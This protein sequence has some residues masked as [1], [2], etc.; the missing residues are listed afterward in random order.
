MDAAATPRHS[1]RRALLAL[2]AVLL[3]VGGFG[4]GSASPAAA[5]AASDESTFLNLLNDTRRAHG[6][7][8]V[9]MNSA[10]SYDARRW[11]GEMVRAGG[12]S[13][14]P[15]TRMVN[16]VARV[17]PS[18]QRIGE[19]VGY[20]ST[21]QQLHNALYNSSGHRANMLGD[22]S[23]V[24][25]GVAYSSGRVWVTFRYVK[26]SPVMGTSTY[27]STVAG[28]PD[29]FASA[30]YA[31]PV[32]WLVSKNITNGVGD[33]GLFMPDAAVN[34]AQMATF[35]WRLAGSPNATAKRFADVPSSAY[36]YKAAM[37]LRAKGITT[38]VGGSN[39]FRPNDIVTREQMA[40]FL[41]RFAG[42]KAISTSHGF[43]DV[44]RGSWAEGAI[45]WLV[46]YDI[47]NGTGPGT[48]SPAGWVTRGQM[49]TFLYRMAMKPK[50]FDSD[51]V[52]IA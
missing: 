24:G 2:L 30:Y 19:N 32:K 34:R 51:G 44:A 18:W 29:V 33:T 35:L 10:L 26:G 28:F 45:K 22:Y 36:Y 38:G 12:L 9:T 8:P 39:Y 25:I 7:G 5:S 27:S 37:W 13:H 47:T 49:A 40:A 21:V 20:A 14:T 31:E 6:L 48:Y 17:V 46:Y 3:V 41:H 52:K 50:S 43:W 15:G 11:T 23:H 4:I 16:E 1:A 42:S